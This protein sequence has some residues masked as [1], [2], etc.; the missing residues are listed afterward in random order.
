MGVFRTLG[1]Y[2]NNDKKGACSIN[3][4]MKNTVIGMTT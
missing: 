1:G 2:I 4:F 3:T